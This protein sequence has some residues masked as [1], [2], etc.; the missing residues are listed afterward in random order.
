M[1]LILNN[2]DNILV[3]IDKNVIIEEAKSYLKD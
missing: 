3:N 2:Y 1:L